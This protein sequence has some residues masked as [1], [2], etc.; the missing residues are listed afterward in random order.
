MGKE[1]GLYT[2]KELATIMGWCWPTNAM[3]TNMTVEELVGMGRSPY[4]G[5]WGGCGVRDRRSWKI[6]LAGQDRTLPTGWC[7]PWATAK[8]EGD[9]CQSAGTGNTGNLLD[10]PG[11]PFP[12]R[13]RSCSCCTALR[14]RQAKPFFL[15]TH[16]MELALR[17]ADKIWL[18][19]KEGGVCHPAP[20]KTCR[21][22]AVWAD[23]CPQ[24]RCIRYRDRPVP[25]R[26]SIRRTDRLTGHGQKFAMARK[27]LQRNGILA[28]RDPRI[29]TTTFKPP[30]CKP[31]AM[32][33]PRSPHTRCH[34]RSP[35]SKQWNN[36]APATTNP[37][38]NRFMQTIY[39]LSFLLKPFTRPTFPKLTDAL[40]QI[41]FICHLSFGILAQ[42][43]Q[44][45]LP[46]A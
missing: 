44:N 38:K 13:W 15:S 39:H 43:I 42:H 12:V 40:W 20:P 28:G 6:H 37:L 35:C 33:L 24:R 2:D 16:D 8:T 41:R 4:T 22:T 19:D 18:M 30:T 34:H 3:Y 36:T 17:L 1:I 9:D 31:P 27:A 11:L 32:C 5:F 14:G 25:H 23:S 46:V 26:Q 10:E 29:L 7:I 21:W 45:I